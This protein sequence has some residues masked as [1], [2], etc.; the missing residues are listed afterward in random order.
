MG[1]LVNREQGPL[2]GRGYEPED[3]TCFYCGDAVVDGIYW[4]GSGAGDGSATIN[5]HH[6]CWLKLA[7][8]LFRDAHEY[9]VTH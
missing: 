5:L 2:V 9:E 6:P 8:R 3:T 7:T 4:V 1:L